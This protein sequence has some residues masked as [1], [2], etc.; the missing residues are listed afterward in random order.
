MKDFLRVIL[1]KMAETKI[2]DV[3][4]KAAK[5]GKADEVGGRW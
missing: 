2:Y 5:T 1:Y 4:E 3:V